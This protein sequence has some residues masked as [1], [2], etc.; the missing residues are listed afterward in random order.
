VTASFG[1]NRDSMKGKAHPLLLDSLYIGGLFFAV[2]YLVAV[3]KG[4]RVI[5]HFREQVRAVPPREGNRHCVWV[6]GVSVGEILS[7]RDFLS[8]F[9]KEFP[10]WEVVLSTT[11]RAGLEAGR[12]HYPGTRV[13]SYP[14][15][16]S[17]LVRRA[18]ERIRPDAV[19]IIEHE[20]W[21][22]FLWHAQARGAPVAIINGRLS[23]R[24]LK[25]YQRLSRLVA[26]P[27]PGVVSFCVEDEVSA[28]GFRRLGVAPERIRVTGNLKFDN[29]PH[30]LPQVREELGLKGTDWVLLGA[31]TH[32]GEED[33][34]L[35]SFEPVHHEDNQARLIIVPRHVE[36]ADNLVDHMRRRG[37]EVLRWSH[38]ASQ[39]VPG[40]VSTPPAP[41]AGAAWPRLVPWSNN[42]HPEVLLVDTVGDLDRILPAADVVFVGGSMVPFGGHNVI[43]PAGIGRPVV[44]G[45][46]YKSFSSV[47]SAFLSRDALLVAK[48]GGDLARKLQELKRD[49]ARAEGIGRRACE[50]VQ[51]RAGASERT[52]EVL[53][54]LFRSIEARG[55]TAGD[56]A[57]A[58]RKSQVT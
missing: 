25:G 16:L 1:S 46:H 57:P 28:E 29:T 52:L 11:T 21:P 8:K 9:C 45:P 10:D 33:M 30:P 44:I 42:G 51:E 35:D 19:I 18:F 32:K 3:G 56:A 12:R 41:S 43:A 15:D 2:P 7:A 37:F 58:T 6:H 39:P 50:T 53:R 5:E 54:P 31:S 47:V 17:H 22:N 49:P 13:I 40:T 55:R 36:R 23:E 14:F 27:P 20:L 34:L 24:S 4:R 48:D 26:W 38:C